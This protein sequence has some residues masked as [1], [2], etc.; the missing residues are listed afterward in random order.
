MTDRSTDAGD[1]VWPRDALVAAL[2]R[3]YG[4]LR[5]AGAMVAGGPAS[6]F[7]SG[8][9]I[10]F[11]ATFDNATGA[12]PRQSHRQRAS[13]H[14]DARQ[15]GVGRVVM[16]ARIE[17]Q[18]DAPPLCATLN[19][20]LHRSIAAPERVASAGK[21]RSDDQPSAFL[22]RTEACAAGQ[23]RDDPLAFAVILLEWERDYAIAAAGALGADPF[24]AAR[25]GLSD[26]RFEHAA[27][28]TT[29]NGRRP[30]LF[31]LTGGRDRLCPTCNGRGKIAALSKN[32]VDCGGLG[33]IAAEI[34]VAD[35][36][37]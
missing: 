10:R 27:A 17:T 13:D 1:R 25:A 12:E 4:E 33:L 36:S 18:G 7:V 11:L 5:P 29:G 28:A 16:S 37:R 8:P 20:R 14:D 34:D 31:G 15:R 2:V 23:E 24:E 30:R 22:L 9:A 3:R 32:C 21:A 19:A 26:N 6:W 35:A